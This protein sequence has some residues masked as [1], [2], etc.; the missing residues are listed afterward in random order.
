MSRMIEINLSP[1][2]RTLRQFGWIALAAFALLAGLAWYER[3]I[4]ALGL[5]EMRSAVAG[6]LASLGLLAGL[7]AL[8]Y[9]RA[10]RPLYIV[11][12]LAA[13][14]I[15]FVLSYVI[16]GA[17]FYLLIVPVGLLFRL[18]GRDPLRRRFEAQVESYWVDA[19]PERARESYFRQF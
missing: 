6:T 16:L 18:V 15:G 8:L 13:V 9:P 2:E 3:L 11:L 19:R 12:T 10:N 5:G 7:A 4:F 17:L 14:P 1:D